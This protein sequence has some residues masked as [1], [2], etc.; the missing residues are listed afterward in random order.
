MNCDN[1]GIVALVSS[2]FLETYALRCFEAGQGWH[3]NAEQVGTRC[4]VQFEAFDF[5]CVPILNRLH[6][7]F[8]KGRWEILPSKLWFFWSCWNIRVMWGIQDCNCL[9]RWSRKI[10]QFWAKIESNCQRV[11]ATAKQKSCKGSFHILAQPPLEVVT[12]CTKLVF[13][14][15]WATTV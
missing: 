9:Q 8:V 12:H 4:G 5:Q 13:S 6:K 14:F 1:C 10:I 7:G 2:F 15:L 3:I 11:I